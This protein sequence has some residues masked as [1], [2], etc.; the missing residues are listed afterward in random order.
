MGLPRNAV[1]FAPIDNLGTKSGCKPQQEIRR[2]EAAY[3]GVDCHVK[4]MGFDRLV[5]RGCENLLRTLA[6]DIVVQLEIAEAELAG[7]YKH[8]IHSVF[9]LR[10]WRRGNCG[11]VETLVASLLMHPSLAKMHPEVAATPVNPF[12]VSRLEGAIARR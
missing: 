6:C 7:S 3:I 5:T 9:E 4:E 10:S 2:Q 1:P 12:S 11:S 8:C